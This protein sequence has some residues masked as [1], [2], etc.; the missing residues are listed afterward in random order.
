MIKNIY[1]KIKP[2][3]PVT[4]VLVLL[5]AIFAIAAPQTFLAKQIY[6][7]FMSAIPFIAVAAA[8]MTLVIIAGEIDMSFASNMALSGF[9]F[10]AVSK[11]VGSP[12]LGIPA[13]LCTGGLIGFINGFVITAAN[14]PSI[15][16]TIGFDFFWRGSVMLL[17]SGLAVSLAA[18]RNSAAVS[19]F[20]GRLGGLIPAQALWALGISFFFALLLHRTPFG[21]AVLM[22]GDNKAA[23][24]MMGLS[25]RKTRIGIFALMGVTAAFAG[26]LSCMEFGNWW[27][28]QGE[29][30][31]LL[32]F[33]SVF[34]GGTSIY[35]GKGSLWGSLAGAIIIGMIE[36]G[37]VSAGFSGFWTRFI[38]G[39]TLVLSVVFYALASDKKRLLSFFRA[40]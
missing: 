12:V 31:L 35:G 8:G 2:L 30:Y 24:E 34:L 27:P 38:H 33:A 10:A 37:L 23:A 7:S 21:D 17:S 3:I 29:G 25:V 40:G 20:T 28:T 18:F 14:A 11:A 15:V 1:A 4:A 22:I 16:V 36:A 5:W 19:V 39:L 26:I 13:A 6:I 32:V 9:V